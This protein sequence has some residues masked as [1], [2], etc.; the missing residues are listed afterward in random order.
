MSKF[1]ENVGSIVIPS[2]LSSEMQGLLLTYIELYYNRGYD[3]GFSD[4]LKDISGYDED[5][6]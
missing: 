5:E 2:E 1:K 3:K 6:E 4:G